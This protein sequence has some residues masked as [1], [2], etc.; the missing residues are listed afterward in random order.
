MWTQIALIMPLSYLLSSSLFPFHLYRGHYQ[1]LPL[2]LRKR[3]QTERTHASA[4]KAVWR[5]ARNSERA[6]IT[7]SAKA[8][9]SRLTASQLLTQDMHYPVSLPE[10]KWPNYQTSSRS[11]CSASK[12]ETLFLLKYCILPEM[13]P[14][15][16]HVN[17]LRKPNRTRI[18]RPADLAQNY[19]SV[20]LPQDYTE[21]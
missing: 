1:H 15:I 14:N 18:V 17:C 4:L 3:G 12:A 7:L 8:W 16:R 20:N 5:P 10:F 11:K 19:W 21:K 9:M 6:A 13:G 2:F